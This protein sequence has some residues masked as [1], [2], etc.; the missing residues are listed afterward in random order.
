MMT[1]T[2]KREFVR[3]FESAAPAGY[4]AVKD[5]DG[6]NPCPWCAP[7]TWTDEG[8]YMTGGTPYECGAAFARKHYAEIA[9]LIA[10]EEA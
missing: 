8:D 4:D 1:D 5:D 3:G 2:E 7:W 10:D 6:S 9:E